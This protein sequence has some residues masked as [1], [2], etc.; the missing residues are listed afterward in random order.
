MIRWIA[1]LVL[2]PVLASAQEAFQLPS[3]NIHCAVHDGRLRCDVLNFTYQRPPRPRGCDLDHGGAVDLG[4]R[5]LPSLICHGD[6]VAN[7]A[8]PVLGYGQAWQ[9]R[10]M[11]CT[12]TPAML[13]CV[14][15][16]GH[17]FEMARARLLFF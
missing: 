12:A 3:G 2:V 7:P 5:G 13:R 6:T 1:A 14:N 4:P 8:A 17:G 11:A 10:G 16:E 15:A 9:G